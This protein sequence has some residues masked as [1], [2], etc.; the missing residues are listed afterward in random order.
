MGK[1]E[2]ETTKHRPIDD[3]TEL[4]A[5]EDIY[6]GL[7]EKPKKKPMFYMVSVLI[8]LAIGITGIVAFSNFSF[9]L[10]VRQYIGDTFEKT[11]EFFGG[12]ISQNRIAGILELKG[13]EKETNVIPYEHAS[14][15]GYISH[16]S[17]I[18]ATRANYIAEFNRKGKM[19]DGYEYYRACNRCGGRLYSSC[20]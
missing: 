18:I 15:A 1:K 17:N 5:E 7:D 11:T 19:G 3:Y 16:N 4:S 20:R 13:E 10:P 9:L 8:V 14:N 12:K 2:P 6:H